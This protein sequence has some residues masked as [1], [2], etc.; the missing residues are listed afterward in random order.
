MK[1]REPP[2]SRPPKEMAFP[3]N[4][5]NRAS[6]FL[7]ALFL[8]VFLGSLGARCGAET[9][10]RVQAIYVFGDSTADVGNNNYLTGS[11]VAKANFPHNG[12]DF[13]TGRPTGRFSNGYNGIDF[14]GTISMSDFLCFL[15]KSEPKQDL[16][17]FSFS[18]CLYVEDFPSIKS[19]KIENLRLFITYWFVFLWIFV[20]S[21]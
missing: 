1:R 21:L 8:F 12:V 15:W 13:P 18:S 20:P 6:S 5:N 7:S 19:I 14:L 4:S 2:S 10:A 17:A 16:I 9:G 3:V 11:N